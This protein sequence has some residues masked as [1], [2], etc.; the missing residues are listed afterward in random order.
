VG[1]GGLRSMME[2]GGSL[3][4]FIETNR[5]KEKAILDA[6]DPGLEDANLSGP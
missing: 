6:D 5:L 4:E 2:S 1:Y 3:L